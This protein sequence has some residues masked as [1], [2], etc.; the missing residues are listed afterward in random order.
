MNSTDHDVQQ[1]T[2]QHATWTQMYE[3][4]IK[5][6]GVQNAKMKHALNM[7]GNR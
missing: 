4:L 5:G 2:K 1:E 7:V 3:I 6:A